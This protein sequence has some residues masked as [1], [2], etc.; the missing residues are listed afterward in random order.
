MSARLE[1]VAVHGG[2][3]GLLIRLAGKNRQLA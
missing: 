2:A 3:G 1:Q